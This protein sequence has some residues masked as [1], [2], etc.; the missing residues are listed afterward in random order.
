[1]GKKEAAMERM[2]QRKRMETA[3]LGLKLVVL[4]GTYSYRE[5]ALGTSAFDLPWRLDEYL[6]LPLIRSVPTCHYVLY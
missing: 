4:A 2:K 5:H 6:G 3:P 1:M